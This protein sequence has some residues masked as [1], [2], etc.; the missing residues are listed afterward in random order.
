M[1]RQKSELTKSGKS[2]GI[3]VTQSEYLEYMKLG[4]AK[5]LRKFLQKIRDRENNEHQQSKSSV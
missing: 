1:P 4:G 2:I 5:W 3:R